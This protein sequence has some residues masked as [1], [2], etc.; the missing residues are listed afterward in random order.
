MTGQ[1]VVAVDGSA[2][3]ERALQTAIVLAKVADAALT[4][5][6]IIEWS[7]FSFHTP[8]EL[9]ERHGR[10]EE[11]LE[12][13][14]DALLGPAEATAKAAGVS[15]ETVVRHGHPA[16]TLIEIA[17]A[18]KASQIFIGRKGQ[19]KMGSLLFGSV[20]GSLVQISSIPVTVVP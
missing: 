11:E 3:S 20:A 9:A 5:V 15:C 10:R 14:R 12:R 17:E 18:T 16:E 4:L 7:P 19:S 8:D 1:F 13:A 2:G 6:H